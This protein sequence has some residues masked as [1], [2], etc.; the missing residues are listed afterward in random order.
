[1]VSTPGSLPIAGRSRLPLVGAEVIASTNWPAGAATARPAQFGA[2]DLE[3]LGERG[4][5]R[6]RGALPDAT[7][8]ITTGRFEVS[9]LP[10]RSRIEARAGTEP[11]PLQVV[12]LAQTRVDGVARRLDLPGV[13]GLHSDRRTG[14]LHRADAAQHGLDREVLGAGVAVAR[15]WARPAASPWRTARPAR[16]RPRRGAAR[17]WQG[18]RV[19][20]AASS[21]LPSGA[22]AFT[23]AAAKFFTTSA[24]ACFSLSGSGL[25]PLSGLLSEQPAVTSRALRQ[26]M[27]AVRFTFSTLARR[28]VHTWNSL[29]RVASLPREQKYSA[30]AG[31]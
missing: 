24:E 27:A 4:V 2:V 1:M 23:Q 17:R 3:V 7:P 14:P 25:P 15:T 19:S 29:R 26:K 10:V 22:H 13:A 18:C 20:A 31:P 16:C 9:G 6:R 11:D 30:A 8:T 5:R 21:G 28:R 12:R